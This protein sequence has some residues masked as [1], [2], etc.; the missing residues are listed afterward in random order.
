M[1]QHLVAT[2][3][4]TPDLTEPLCELAAA[5]TLHLP[6]TA[7]YA[8]YS[9]PW[10]LAV[11]RTPVAVVAASRAEDVATAVAW[12]DAHGVTVAVQSTG[13]G[14]AGSLDGALLVSTRDLT[15]LAVDPDARVLVLVPQLTARKAKGQ[16]K[17]NEGRE[18]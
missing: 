7:G 10:N 4:T 1:T 8:A 18:R 12:A 2:A 15:D 3:H 16:G 6:G 5:V 14:P 9:T 17:P 11:P 13:H